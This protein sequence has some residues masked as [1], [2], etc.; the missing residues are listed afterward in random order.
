MDMTQRQR[1][2][3]VED[4]ESLRN[5]MR[6]ALQQEG[7]DIL[8]AAS[9]D[10]AMQLIE[11]QPYDLLLTDLKLPGASGIE[12]LRASRKR[13]P[14]IPV[15]VLTAFG[16]VHTA[17]QAMKLGAA[18][19]LEKPVEIDDLFKLTRELIGQDDSKSSTTG[20]FQAPGG[21]LII[22][23]HPSLRAS[24]RLLSKVASTGSTVLLTGES[25]TGKELF[26]RSLHQLSARAHGPFVAINCAAIPETLMENE[27]FGHE[28]GAFT[29]AHGR[30]T[31]RFELAKGGTLFL[32]EIGELALGVQSKVLRVLEERTFE[33][34]GSGRSIVADVR[35]V[36]ATNRNLGSMVKA[37]DFRQDLYFR[38]DVFPIELPALRQR[39]SDISLLAPHLLRVTA[40]RL[41]LPEATLSQGAMDLLRE[42]PWPGNVRQLANTLERALILSEGGVLGE[43][44]L[45]GILTP[46]TSKRD[47]EGKI[48][49]ALAATGGDKQQAAESLGVSYRSLQ[50]KIR[51]LDLEGF[52]KYR[53]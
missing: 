5:L 11:D 29:G 38:L 7:Y 26:A 40:E 47:W 19:F 31:G 37:G 2:F 43:K 28:K 14:E 46:T 49:H 9:G 41:G 27:L 35:V 42:Q 44:E 25:G 3:I 23:K 10:A 12:V 39:P 6:K 1:V 24:L 8:S 21:P 34:V 15:V 13:R 17:V 22:G 36:A 20:A 30:Q 48:R 33:R 45:R 51:Q 32:D 53:S 16:N 52:P 4:R 50:R 18:D